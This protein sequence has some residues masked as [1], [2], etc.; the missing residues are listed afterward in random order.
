MAPKTIMRRIS[1]LSGFYR[2]MREIAA[3]HRLPIV[4][5]NP[6]HSQFLPRGAADPV[7]ETQALSLSKARQL[8][9]FP[10]GDGVLPPATGRF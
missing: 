4:V 5:P 8:I 9:S 6:A 2:F 7:D 3:D 10:A 1:S